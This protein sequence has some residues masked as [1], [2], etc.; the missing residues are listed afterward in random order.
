MANEHPFGYGARFEGGGVQAIYRG[1]EMVQCM[2][3]YARILVDNYLVSSMSSNLDIIVNGS[4]KYVALL[5]SRPISNMGIITFS[6]VA[7]SI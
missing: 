4:C 7:L 3:V 6:W 5:F 1:G 2:I